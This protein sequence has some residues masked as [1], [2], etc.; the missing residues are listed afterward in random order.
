M[1]SRL[2]YFLFYSIILGFL[3]WI[4]TLE[5]AILFQVVLIMFI[6]V[7]SEAKDEKTFSISWAFLGLFTGILCL[8]DFASSIL[9]LDN[10]RRWSFI[11]LILTFGNRLILIPIWLIVLGR[12]LPRAIKKAE[13]RYEEEKNNTAAA[14]QAPVEESAPS[15]ESS[16]R[17]I[18]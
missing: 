2:S 15:D 13:M 6:S 16:L 4:D 10:W 17:T 8:F 9:R 7:R 12:Q 1:T 3:L 14:Q 18:T 5:W 11:T